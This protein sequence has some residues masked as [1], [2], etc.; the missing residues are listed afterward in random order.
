MPCART[1][2]V[3]ISKINTTKS[4]VAHTTNSLQFVSDM[5][6]RCL[7]RVVTQ[8]GYQIYDAEVVVSTTGWILLRNSFRWVVHTSVPLSPSTVSWYWNKNREAHAGYMEL[9]WS[10]DNTCH[11]LN[12]M[13]QR[14]KPHLYVTPVRT[15]ISQSCERTTLTGAHLLSLI[16]LSTTVCYAVTAVIKRLTQQKN[17]LIT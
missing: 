8:R 10:V 15:C 5:Q 7:G 13:K 1:C 16:M 14:W 2:T 6:L 11:K 12:S 4:N 9:F 3:K 17:T